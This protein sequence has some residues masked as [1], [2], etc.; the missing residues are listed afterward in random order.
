MDRITVKKIVEVNLKKNKLSRIFKNGKTLETYNNFIDAI[1][2]RYDLKV[3]MP[4]S[5]LDTPMIMVA[6]HLSCSYP[7]VYCF[8]D[9][10]YVVIDTKTTIT[11]DLEEALELIEKQF[12]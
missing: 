4:L 6:R 12:Y 5:Q 10:Y 11:T 3:C 7:V 8:D 2:K 9:K 1:D